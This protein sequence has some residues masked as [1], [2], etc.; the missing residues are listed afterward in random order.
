M[1][2]NLDQI[3]SDIDLDDLEVSRSLVAIA[4]DPERRGR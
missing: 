3:V 2:N 4:G 1:L